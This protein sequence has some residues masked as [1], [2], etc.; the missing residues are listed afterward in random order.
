MTRFDLVRRSLA[1]ALVA[2]VAVPA[3]AQRPAPSS[4]PAEGER[5]GF[6][7]LKVLP[8]DI[9]E[10]DL[11]AV[12]SGFT[13]ALGVGCRYCHVGEEGK[14]MRHEDF[15]LD[16]KPTKLKARE[17]MKMATAINDEYLAKLDH[18]ADPPLKVECVTCHHGNPQ[19]RT[20]QAVLTSAYASGGMDSTVARYHALRDRYYGRFTYDFSD[21]PLADVGGSLLDGGH[22]AD[23]ESLLAMNVT[24]NPTSSFAKR[25]LASATLVVAFRSGADAGAAAVHDMRGRF[26]DGV[27]GEDMVNRLAYNLLGRHED[28]AAVAAFR[29]NTVDY[30]ASANAWDSLGEGLM[31][32]G[33][34]KGAKQAFTKALELNPN[35]DN[36]KQK[37]EALK[38]APRAAP[39]GKKGTGA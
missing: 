27:V 39:R 16:D 34:A 4:A 7:N 1:L 15:Q 5:E 38:T 28:A 13:R 25:Q 17:M 35:D 31:R 18:R 37:L 3:F 29:Q 2:A 32:T 26:G 20:L 24:L 30:P 19:P 33:D 11:D 36:A 12:M 8:K 10:K 14:P 9:S 22:A 23:A 6:K 21:V